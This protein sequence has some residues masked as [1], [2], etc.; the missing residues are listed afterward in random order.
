MDIQRTVKYISLIVLA[1]TIMVISACDKQD[2]PEPIVGTHGVLKGKVKLYN[3]GTTEMPKE[4][5]IVSIFG[6]KPLISDTTDANGNFEFKNL[7]YGTYSISFSKTNYGFSIINRISHYTATTTINKLIELGQFST[8][9]TTAI[10]AKDTLG[11]IQISVTTKIAGTTNKP[12]YIRLF[13]HTTDQVSSTDFSNYSA[14]IVATTNPTIIRLNPH[15]IEDMGFEKGSV[16]WVK[17]YGD[18][19]YSN[20]YIDPLKGKHIFPNLNL[21]SAAADSFIVP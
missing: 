3:D 9:E 15:M 1:I 4:G 11:S 2:E 12:R 8:T 10:Q 13:Y 7:V 16:V 19:Y 21:K 5:M 6:S 20:D 18:S 17:A 14:V